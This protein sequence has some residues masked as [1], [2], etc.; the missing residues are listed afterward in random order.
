MRA[1]HFVL[2]ATRLDAMP[3]TDREYT[4]FRP[5][6]PMR[7]GRTMRACWNSIPD[8]S[9]ADFVERMKSLEESGFCE[10]VVEA[11]AVVLAPSG[12]KGGG[13][14]GVIVNAEN[15]RCFDCLELLW[16][17]KAL[18]EG[19]SDAVSKGIG[20]YRL[21]YEKGLPSYYIGEYR[22]AAGVMEV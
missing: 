6:L 21:G 8:K 3:L 13:K 12:K 18:Q 4:V 15:S 11:P 5:D 17:A 19:V 16:K 20:L 7:V 1:S 22:D 2:N 10:T 14:T 9:Y